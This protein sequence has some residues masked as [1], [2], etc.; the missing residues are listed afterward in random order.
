MKFDGKVYQTFCFFKLVFI[1]AKCLMFY[2]LITNANFHLN[3]MSFYQIITLN[4]T[5]S[6]SLIYIETKNINIKK[7]KILNTFKHWIN[8][9]VKCEIQKKK[10]IANYYVDVLHRISMLF[11]YKISMSMWCNVLCSFQWWI[12][13]IT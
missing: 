9:Q 8:F 5:E 4:C 6:S 10:F 12:V 1:L 2:V 11:I 7:T 3:I 13:Y